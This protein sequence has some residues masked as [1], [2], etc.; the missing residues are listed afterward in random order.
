MKSFLAVFVSAVLTAAAFG[1]SNAASNEKFKAAA[2]EFKEQ[3]YADAQ[4]D[5]EKANKELGG[6]CVECLLQAATA[7]LESGHEDGGWKLLDKAVATAA[8]P[9]DRFRALTGRAALL[10]RFPSTPKVLAEEEKSARQALELR[11]DDM[12]AHF[13]HALALLRQ[14]RDAE[15]VAE[16]KLVAAHL[17]DGPDKKN[18]EAFIADPRRARLTFAP[19]FTA[20]LSEG[21]T[22]KLADFKGKVLLI[23][24]W[25]TWCPPCRESV[26]ELKE[27]HKKYG[28]RLAVMSVSADESQKQW[29]DYILKHDMSW[30]QSWDKGNKASVLNAFGVHL[31]PTYVLI[32]AEGIVRARIDGLNT[33]ETLGH[34]MKPALE[35]LLQ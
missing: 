22:V 34:R 26:P 35:K 33:Q 17:E 12:P 23:D 31:F 32:D 30:Q 14:E 4:R 9:G 15:G 28:D 5:F 10:Y 25:A 8:T 20:A 7:A 13:G 29:S 1:Q 3:H 21:K 18:V 2:T 16:M 24:F 6:H 11:P 19:D 27:L